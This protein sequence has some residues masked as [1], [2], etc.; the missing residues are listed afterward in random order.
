MQNL[1]FSLI[2]FDQAWEDKK[3]NISKIERFIKEYVPH[4]TDVIVL[5][6]MFTTGFSMK[7]SA[8]A[9]APDGESFHWMKQT[10][11]ALNKALCGS[12]IIKE[13]GKYYNRFY[14]I[15]PD[16]NYYCYN[17]RHL[18]TMAGEHHQYTAGM[19]KLVFVYKDFRI[20][21]M[22]CFD[23]R[24][25]AWNRNLEDYDVLLIV[26]NW[27]EKRI[28]HWDPLIIARAI[29]NQSYVVAVNRVGP[30]GNGTPHNGHSMAVDPMGKIIAFAADHETV[31]TFSI[32]K[33]TI[34]TTRKN[35]PFLH[36]R[37]NFLMKD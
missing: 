1:T 9:E 30:D 6:E 31:L 35:L 14:F 34:E 2:Q 36:E 11:S 29:E 16:G 20:C 18:F 17:K 22:I 5:P 13:K 33:D 21:P 8:L 4:E 25:P 19:E 32:Q 12:L 23:L 27:P 3:A 28:A 37:D 24:F 26:A 15:Q 7:P 10:A